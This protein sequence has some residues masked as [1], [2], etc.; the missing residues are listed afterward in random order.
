M[1]VYMTVDIYHTR[2]ADLYGISVEQFPILVM[3]RKVLNRRYLTGLI[4]FHVSVRGVRNSQQ[5]DIRLYSINRIYL[6]QSQLDRGRVL[7]YS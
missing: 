1:L 5:A 3:W 4:A 2:V 7:T 6:V